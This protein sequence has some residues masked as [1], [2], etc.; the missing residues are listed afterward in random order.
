MWFPTGGTCGEGYEL[1]GHRDL[2]EEE[3]HLGWALEVLYPSFHVFLLLPVYRISVMLY[4]EL[5]H[6]LNCILTSGCDPTVHPSSCQVFAYN[7]VKGTDD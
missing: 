1:L 5:Y 4:D 7:N 6:C 3:G 2:L